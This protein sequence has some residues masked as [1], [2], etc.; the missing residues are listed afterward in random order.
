MAA[1]MGSALSFL[2]DRELVH[3]DVK[4]PN[5]LVFPG[6]PAAPGSGSSPVAFTLKMSDFGMKELKAALN[7]TRALPGS[8]QFGTWRAPNWRAPEAWEA[9]AL[10]TRAGDV[11]GLGCTLYELAAHV[12][13]WAGIPASRAHEIESLVREGYRPERPDGCTDLFWE[14]V[15]KAW[16]GPPESRPTMAAVSEELSRY[17]TAACQAEATA[18]KQQAAA[19][20]TALQAVRELISTAMPGGLTSVVAAMKRFAF[21]AGVA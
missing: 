14:V 16:E 5:F 6:P 20:E 17:F 3:G 2:H 21:H 19:A 12:I 10:D 15:S 11:Y 18:K 13:P 7:T 4:S 9:G 1:N 8:P